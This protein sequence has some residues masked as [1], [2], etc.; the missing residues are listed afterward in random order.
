[1]IDY[2]NKTILEE[3]QFLEECLQSS[4]SYA[5]GKDLLSLKEVKYEIIK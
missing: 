1:L 4:I 2:K 5:G 3:L